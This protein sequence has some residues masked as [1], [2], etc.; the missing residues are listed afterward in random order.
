MLILLALRAL[1]STRLDDTFEPVLAGRMFVLAA[2]LLFG[3]GDGVAAAHSE[4]HLLPQRD[5]PHQVREF[6]D[7]MGVA[8]HL[9]YFDTA[10]GNF[11]LV[12]QRLKELGI[13]H[14]RDG[15]QLISPDYDRRLY[16]SWIGLA[17]V[18]VH[19]D[20]VL[21]PRESLKQITPQ[22]LKT[23]D[24]LSGGGVIESLE[25]PNELDISG[26]P[27]WPSAARDYQKLIWSVASNTPGFKNIPVYGPSMAQA[28]NAS[29]MGDLSPY[30]TEGNLHPYPGGNLPSIIFP[31]QPSLMASTYPNRKLVFTETGYHN[32]LA[33]HSDQPGISE[34]AAAKYIPRIFLEDFNHGIARTFLYELFDEKPNPELTDNQKHFGLLRSDGSRKPAFIALR[35]MIAILNRDSQAGDVRPATLSYV[36]AGMT[37]EIHHTLL[38]KRP[39]VYDLILWREVSSFDLKSGKDIA[40]TKR[41]V[42]LGFPS[43]PAR[44]LLFDPL[45]GEDHVSQASGRST[46]EIDVPDSPVIVKI[47]FGSHSEISPNRAHAEKPP[48]ASGNSSR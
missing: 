15:A 18:G 43:P 38:V 5:T 29:R 37:P 26:I 36:A 3:L 21:D 33:D 8:A 35:N 12:Q 22:K 46:Y 19:I 11:P 17:D 44:V 48:T 45:T 30:V 34:S 1:F 40:N 6:V 14:V 10:Y 2:L 27:N 9:N 47:Q 39:G 42:H 41:T 23:I 28:A 20:L 7:S 24:S 16:D 32:A 25:G 13:R 4:G 31:S